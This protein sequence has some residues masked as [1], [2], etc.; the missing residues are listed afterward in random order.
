MKKS[1]NQFVNEKV[2]DKLQKA[3]N[4]SPDNIENTVLNAA[5][6]VEKEK[7]SIELSNND[8]RSLEG[9]IHT[10]EEEIEGYVLIKMILREE[11]D[12]A[13]VFYRDNKSYFNVFVD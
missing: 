6:E 1:L 12:P 7:E 2:N 11:I 3:L 5:N 13:R 9:A 10:T 4:S 8:T